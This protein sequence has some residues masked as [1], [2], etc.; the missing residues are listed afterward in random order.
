[1]RVHVADAYSVEG[2]AGDKLKNLLVI[3][4]NRF[5]KLLQSI[6]DRVPRLE[7]THRQF[8][9]H[10]W[11]RQDSFLTEQLRQMGIAAP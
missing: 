5:R 11:M 6:Q 10:K 7:I 3:R 4:N 1:M 2:S 8:T 9:D